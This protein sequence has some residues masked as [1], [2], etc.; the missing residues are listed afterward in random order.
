ME[1]P[2][3]SDPSENWLCYWR[4][5][6]RPL[7]WWFLF[8]LVLYGIRLHQRLMAGTY[9][10]FRVTVEGKPNPYAGE[11]IRLDGKNYESG[12][13]V[14]LGQHQLTISNPKTETYTQ[15]LFVWYG[16]HDLGKISLKR[17]QGVLQII[18][19]PP[20]ARLQIQGPEFSTQLTGANGFN[21]TVPTD[22]YRVSATYTHWNDQMDVGV[23]A[24]A[25]ASREFAPRF[26]ALDITCNQ[27]SA[28]FELRRKENES[29][30][31][32]GPLPVVIPGLPAG[33]YRLHLAY[34][35]HE[36]TE[37]VIVKFGTTNQIKTEFAFGTAALETRPAGAAVH[38]R[39]GRYL[40]QTPLTLPE[41]QPGSWTFQLKLAG[42][43]P[44]MTTLEI[45]ADE[46]QSF[47]TNLVSV[48]YTG[49]MRAARGYMKTADYDRALS[50]LGD[51]LLAKPSDAAASEL[52]LEASGQAAIQ[53]ARALAN[54]GNYI[55]A[56]TLLTA[57]L[58]ALPGN[59]EALELQPEYKKHEPEQLERIRLERLSRVR[60]LFDALMV[61]A[62]AS[63]LFETRE[64]KTAKPAKDIQVAL[65]NALQSDPPAGQPP[66]KIVRYTSPKPET[67]YIET[68]QE[69]STVLA[70]SAGKRCCYIVG[71]Q[72]KDDETQ[73]LFK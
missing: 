15:K 53:K 6:L 40:G 43:E 3:P 31:E 57:A 45:A 26:G 51:A 46:T 54:T 50:A 36:K 27:S 72:T 2:N 29:A 7:A 71:G 38:D 55:E 18:C 60:N 14:S 42:Y 63:A 16:V 21:A 49:A 69:F 10:S 22:N 68:V 58:L 32:S 67:F 44:V 25:T 62:P 24:N 66:V 65:N 11:R 19:D 34:H 1:S 4:R 73:I 8:V 39:A 64:I 35:G 48:G 20:A 9:L 17:S 37:S 12:Q 30:I 13:L 59:A 33:N 52:Q 23:P 70:T 5:V 28:T 41:L 56:G 61:Q 47:R